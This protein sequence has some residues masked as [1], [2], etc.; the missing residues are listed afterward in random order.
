VR[1]FMHP[2]TICRSYEAEGSFVQSG[3][4]HFVPTGL[5]AAGVRS[6]TVRE[7]LIR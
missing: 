5:L 2:E 4:K 7:G 1:R 6:P 3:Y